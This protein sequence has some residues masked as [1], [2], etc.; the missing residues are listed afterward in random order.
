MKIR[1]NE[2]CPF[3]D[4]RDTLIHFFVTCPVAIAAWEE[5]NMIVADICGKQMTLTEG[6]KMLGLLDHD[7][8]LRSDLRKK[9]NNIILVCKKTISKYKYEKSG[10]IKNLLKNQLYFRNLI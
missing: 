10:D 1:N 6:N 4:E 8:I 2:L 9:I 3:C 5:V 7:M